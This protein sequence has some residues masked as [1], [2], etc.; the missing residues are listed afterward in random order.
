[1]HLT[2]WQ[3]RKNWTSSRLI[4]FF[5]TVCMRLLCLNWFQRGVLF[6]EVLPVISGVQ[7]GLFS[8]RRILTNAPWLQVGYT[9]IS[10]KKG[11]LNWARYLSFLILRSNSGKVER[12]SGLYEPKS[13]PYTFQMH[14]LFVNFF[15]YLYIYAPKSANIESLELIAAW[16]ANAHCTICAQ[17]K[18]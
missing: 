9:L 1:M 14:L 5:L 12:F 2:K 6:W 4:Y 13:I 3:N 16:L 7:P 18:V 8:S 10:V 15:I 11:H 17:A